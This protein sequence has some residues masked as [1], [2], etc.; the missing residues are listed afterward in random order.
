[1]T[2]VYVDNQKKRQTYFLGV[3]VGGHKSHALITDGLG[4][5]LGFGN[6]GSGN[7]EDVGYEGL[8]EVIVDI[9]EQA[10]QQ[11]RIKIDHIAGAGFGIA[12]YDWPSQRQKTLEAL[13][14][15]NLRAP[16]EI[17]NDTVIGLIAGSENGWGVVVVAGSGCNCRGWNEERKEGRVISGADWAAEDAGGSYLVRNAIK[18]IALQ[19]TKRGPATKLTQTFISKN[20]VANAAELLEG[21][22]LG[23]ILAVAAD[24]PLVFQVAE[25]GDEVAQRLVEDMG[26]LLA[27]MACG[28]IRQLGCEELAFDVVLVG[29]LYDGSPRLIEVMQEGIQELAPDAHL[30]RLK[31]PPVVGGVLLG[32]ELAGLDGKLIRGNLLDKTCEFVQQN[33]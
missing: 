31:A 27:D 22:A 20:D 4:N 33:D 16:L 10:L 15:L 2:R 29:S 3:D 12:G 11:A 18:S 32:M 17:V 6:G 19:W 7:W 28:V 30:I 21:F 1:M 13:K 14:P 25:E 8:R 9:T 26:R 24:A 5:P 23:N